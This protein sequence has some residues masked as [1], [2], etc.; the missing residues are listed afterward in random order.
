MSNT[1][2][3][4]DVLEMERQETS[5]PD[6]CKVIF[7]NDNVTHVDFVVQVLQSVFRKDLEEAR[8]LTKNIHEK[9]SAVVGL[10]YEEIAIMKRDETIRLARAN[11]YPLRVEVEID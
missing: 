6:I 4:T 1:K 11:N 3:Q 9:G 5:E 7:Y 10:Y 2:Y 8:M